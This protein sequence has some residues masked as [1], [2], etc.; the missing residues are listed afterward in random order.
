MATTKPTGDL[1]QEMSF[2]ISQHA[3]IFSDV[4]F[5]SIG[6]GAIVVNERGVISRVNKPALDILGYDETDL[7]GQWYPT[8]V[9]AEDDKG[10][11]IPNIDRPITEVFLSGQTVFRRLRYRRKDGSVVAVS[12]SVAPIMHGD[13]PIGAIQLFRD[14]TDEL[15]LEHAKDE[16]ISIASH[17]LRTPATVVKQYLGM[18]L[19]GFVGSEEKQREMI[20]V[21]YEHNDH[22][23]DIVNNLL[24]VAQIE[25]KSLVPNHTT[26]DLIHILKKIIKSQASHYEMRG[27]KLEL[28]TEHDHVNI[29]VDPLHVQ[30]VFENLIDNANKYSESNTSVSVEVSDSPQIVTVHVKDQGVGIDKKDVSKLFQKFSRVNNHTATVNGTGLGLYWAKKLI[31]LYGGD[32]TVASKLHKGTTFSVSLPKNKRVQ[33]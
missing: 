5:L 9:I 30:M 19:E 22:Q 14:I 31:Q 13:K 4:L 16:F 18:I 29:D 8:A 17:Q 10:A 11:V 27:I 23:L 24:K 3:D 1:S 6:E 21:A 2:G 26:T 12:L 28:S 33:V 7:V 20:Q 15:R 25:S 32:I